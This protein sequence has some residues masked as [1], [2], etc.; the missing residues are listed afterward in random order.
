MLQVNLREGAVTG[1]L[2]AAG[3]AGW[4][5]VVDAVAGHP[6]F[7]PNAL[8]G[9]VF[10]ALGAEVGPPEA[11]NGAVVAGYTLI[12]CALFVL[13]GVIASFIVRAGESQPAVLALFMVLFA[14]IEM[15][16][17]G[18]TAV[19]DNTGALGRMAWWQIAGGN[20]VATLLMGFY[21][22]RRHPGIRERL[23]YALSR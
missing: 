1:L 16:F 4:F 9:M 7:T 8:G 22:F 11:I 6:L 14:I 17:Y 23:D 15:G 3:V 18:A 20:L 21:L 13:V 2:G 5:L 10:R 19:L 12:H